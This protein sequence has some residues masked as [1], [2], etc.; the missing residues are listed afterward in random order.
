MP[1][2]NHRFTRQLSKGVP[3]GN[4]KLQ[5]SKM[6][7]RKQSKALWSSN[8]IF[9]DLNKNIKSIL[10]EVY[11]VSSMFK[12]RRDNLIKELQ[13]QGIKQAFIFDPANVFYYTGF[14]SEPHER[15]MAFFIETETEENHLFVPALDK[16]AAEEATDIQSIQAI[17]DEENPYDIIE[18]TIE[19]LTGKLGIEGDVLAYNRSMAF[20]KSFPDIQLTDIQAILSTIRMA[21][22]PEE[23]KEIQVAIDLIEDVLKQGI[24]KVQQGMTEV[25][26]TAEL[27]YL[28]RQLG[29]DGPSFSTIVLAGEKAALPHGVP[30]ERKIQSGDLLLIDFGVIKNSY[31]S[32]ITRT[33]AIGEPS[34]RQRELYNLV[35]QATNAGIEAVQAG[36]PL[37]DIDK[38]AR[39][40]IEDAGYGAYFNNRIGHGMGIDVHEA[41]SVHATNR[42]LAEKGMVFTI[43]P[44]IYIPG[45]VGIRIEDNVY[46]N[47]EGEAEVLTSF[48]K[49]LQS[50]T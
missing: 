42:A 15:F 12:A 44:G 33:F 13:N 46:I 38:A 8:I 26:L 6:N 41:P 47:P 17:S 32:D 39:K 28:M 48:P 18:K 10:K 23:I 29:A 37:Q 27:E 49:N 35:L 1:A 19:S 9:K 3:T 20:Q 30:G 24:S 14:H 43:E 34:S 16:D 5:L 11:K 7:I 45:E 40:V 21:K 50:I 36:V 2:A 25:E 22:S 4:A 31:C